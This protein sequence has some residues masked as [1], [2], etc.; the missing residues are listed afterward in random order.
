[1]TFS[2]YVLI[3]GTG[4]AAGF[5]NTVAGGGSLLTLPLLI[6][7][8]LP[9]AEAN[10]SNRVAIFIQN[11]FA[12]KGFKSKGIAVFPFAYWVSISATLGALL[13]A[14]LA[15]EISNSSFNK[16]LSIVMIFVLVVTVLKPYLDKK[17]AFE[18]FTKKRNLVS[19]LLF[20]SI[21]I[22]GGF[23]QA[24]VGFIIMA[25][26]TGIHGLNLAK[27]NSVKVFVVLCYT[28]MALLVFIY[29]GKV[30]W[31]YGLILA[32]GNA[33]GGWIASRWSVGVNE[34]WIRLILILTLS[35]LALKLWMT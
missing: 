15:T 9:A 34:K 22:Y 24:G 26:L 14:Y 13:G 6:F 30:L 20:F 18:R 10:G 23:I 17:E 31:T 4:I 2:D 21:G 11:I 33:I 8:G 29:N 3:I 1:M 7:M 12:V 19:I 32:V 27:T 16:I 25:A 5:I 28:S 35:V